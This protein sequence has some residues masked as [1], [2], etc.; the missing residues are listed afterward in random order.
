MSNNNRS[1]E[2][3]DVEIDWDIDPTKYNGSTWGITVTGT[4]PDSHIDSEITSGNVSVSV[5]EKYDRRPTP[6]ESKVH[7]R[8]V[9]D[10]L[11]R[12]DLI[13]ESHTPDMGEYSDS[14]PDSAGD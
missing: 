6:S 2:T 3:D 9:V 1:D 5:H 7:I 4:I 13:P 14:D 8:Q 10:V 12:A 11:K